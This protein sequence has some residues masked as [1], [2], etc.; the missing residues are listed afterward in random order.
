M[1]L[2]LKQIGKTSRWI[3]EN[4]LL[5]RIT[6]KYDIIRILLYKNK[7]IIRYDNEPITMIMCK[8]KSD[9]I[10]LYN[11]LSDKIRTEKNQTNNLYWGI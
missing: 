2:I 5:G 9:A 10:R 3:Y 11:H 8:N 6:N 1:V 7:L 4:L